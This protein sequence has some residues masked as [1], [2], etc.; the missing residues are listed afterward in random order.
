MDDIKN[1]WLPFTPNKYFHDNPK[2]LTSA[3]GIYYYDETGRAI[4]DSSAG[5]WCV[6]AGH[7]QQKII[8]A[9]GRQAEQLDYAPSFQVS[10]PLAFKTATAL[11]ELAPAGFSHAFFTNSGS[12]AVD[13]S[14]KVALQYHQIKG[15]TNRI[16]LIGRE[17]DY[18]G[19]GFGGISIGGLANNQKHFPLLPNIGHIPHTHDLEKNAFSRGLPA[20]GAELAQ[21]V[22]TIDD[23]QGNIAAVI[24]EPL[25]GS[26][27][28][29][30]PPEGYLQALRN[31]CD[32]IGALLI[33][34]EV[35]TG[36]GRIGDAFAA[37]RF[38]VTPDIIT[39]AKGLTNGCMPMGA[40]LIKDEIYQTILSGAAGKTIEFFH[41]FTYSAHPLACATAL[42]TL[43]VYR[44]Q[45]LF[46]R[47][48]HLESHFE[49]A[50]H[51]LRGLANIIDIRNFGLVGAI[52]L[53]PIYNQPGE[54]AFRIFEYCFNKG[55]LIR[56]TGDTIA[57]SPPLIIE[58]DEIDTIVSIISD[59]INA[60][61]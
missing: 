53:E 39:L 16:R 21:F 22:K 35:I 46:E 33:F 34:D 1:F 61:Q 31:Y 14:L 24:V 41:G 23:D 17:K 45:A 44:E 55:L 29:Y 40:V 6:N 13:T 51:G 60:T 57:L 36:F 50:I 38:N 8:D 3:K 52:E 49:N 4:L 18:H 27:G 43:D 48:Q 15:D 5:L 30:L 11:C 7:H 19:V 56:I 58:K 59:A 2:L 42:A 12:E 26:V 32:D 9:I 28:V 25:A 20:F 47:S 54:R 10:H 37:N